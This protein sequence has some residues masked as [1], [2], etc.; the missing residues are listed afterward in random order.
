MIGPLGVGKSHVATALA[1]GAIRAGHRA[2]IRST[3]DLAADF[4][5]ADAMG[6]RREFVQQLTASISSSSK[7][8]G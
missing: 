1:V 8:S 5:Q 7:T 4:V 6:T 2:R 3:F